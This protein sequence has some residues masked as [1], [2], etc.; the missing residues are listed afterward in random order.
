MTITTPKPKPRPHYV[1]APGRPP[2]GE[3]DAPVLALVMLLGRFTVDPDEGSLRMFVGRD[4]HWAELEARA[5]G[6]LNPARMALS[7]AGESLYWLEV[8]RRYD[9]DAALARSV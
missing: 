3:M 9:A 7:T 6:L 2:P 8:A 5:R 1:M 4:W